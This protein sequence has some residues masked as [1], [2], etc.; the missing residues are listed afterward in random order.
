MIH[1]FSEDFTVE[2]RFFVELSLDTW[3][4]EVIEVLSFF[5]VRMLR[6]G[7]AA[8]CGPSANSGERF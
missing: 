6:A 5:V 3:N 1:Y 4:T 8:Q 2:F 7:G